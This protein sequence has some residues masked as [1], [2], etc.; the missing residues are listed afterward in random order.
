MGSLAKIIDR[1][2]MLTCLLLGYAVW[3]AGTHTNTVYTA[4][5]FRTLI[6]AADELEQYQIRFQHI[7]LAQ[8]L[9]ETDEFRSAI[10]RDCKN[11]FGM[12]V[13]SSRPTT[14]I[15]KCRGHARYRSY[16]DSVLDYAEWQ[17][18]YLPRYER[19]FGRVTTN[20]Q[21]YRFLRAQNYAEDDEYIQKLRKWV[22][23][24]APD[25]V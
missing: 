16:S 5:Y 19:R 22:K 18:K 11:L 15:G 13:A 4:D 24:I 9:H 14:S 20:E 2:F 21:Y 10:C 25:T 6:E 8:A 17:M 7:A 12:K 3:N 1:V 23:V